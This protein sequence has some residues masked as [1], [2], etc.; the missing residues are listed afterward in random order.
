MED[1]IHQ[2][3]VTIPDYDVIASN[4]HAPHLDVRD[5]DGHVAG[6]ELLAVQVD[7]DLG[8]TGLDGGDVVMSA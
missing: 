7:T 4:E 6:V 1:V 3:S 5:E 2:D 8:R